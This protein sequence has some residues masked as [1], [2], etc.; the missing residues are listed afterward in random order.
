M[1]AAAGFGR[2]DDEPVRALRRRDRR[3]AEKPTAEEP[4]GEEH[5]GEKLTAR[6]QLLFT[7]AR[8]SVSESVPNQI[9]PVDSS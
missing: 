8:P 3:A 9:D 7:R 1:A 6:D 2:V 4:T 5:A